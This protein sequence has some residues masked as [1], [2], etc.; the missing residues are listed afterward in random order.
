MKWE[1]IY[2]RR[3]KGLPDKKLSEFIYKLLNNLIMCRKVLLKW[4]R[5]DTEECP[6]CGSTETIKHI[7]FDCNLMRVV[8]NKVGE[9][10][11]LNITWEKVI[12][13]F[14]EDLV[15]HNLRNLVISLILYVRYKF[16]LKSLE[17]ETSPSVFKIMM[18]KDIKMWNKIINYP[19]YKNHVTFKIQWNRY[20]LID[21]LN[22]L[23]L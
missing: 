18:L 17:E 3:V 16:W 6:L 21:S 5:S 20:S 13:G 7:Y 22:S 15:I 19:C 8:W 11:K 12:L 4:K 9:C 1:Y 2:M 23:T 14:T 10:L